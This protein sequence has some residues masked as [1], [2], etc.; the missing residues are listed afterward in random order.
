VG[1]GPSEKKFME[2]SAPYKYLCVSI[3]LTSVCL[4]RT[5][6][7]SREQR[8]PERPKLAQTWLGQYFQDQVH[9]AALLTAAITHEAGAVCVRTYWAWETTATLRLLGGSRG[10][11]VPKGRGISC[12][13]V[14]SLLL[15]CH[16]HTRRHQSLQQ[17]IYRTLY[18]VIIFMF[19]MI[20]IPTDYT[21][22]RCR[23]RG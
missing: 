12:H 1:Q 4:L 15:L 11:A 10:A 3:C 21:L 16:T 14:Q 8:G 5:S 6:G 18:S 2:Q 23:I 22:K 13:H 17:S 19:I 20:V 9:Q 7:L